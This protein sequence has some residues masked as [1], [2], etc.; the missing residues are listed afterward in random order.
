MIHVNKIQTDNSFTLFDSVPYDYFG[1]REGGS[2]HPKGVSDALGLK[3]EDVSKIT[4]V[5]L[6]SVRYDD[7]IPLQVRDRLEEIS[8]TI[9]MVAGFFDGDT[10]KTVLWFKTRNP[11]LGDIS[12]RDMIRLGR[13]ERLRKF[14]INAA[15]KKNRPQEHEI[16]N[17]V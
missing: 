4:S 9:N 8:N 16:S 11:L 3:R 2:F 14:I 6:S 12:P 5:S 10:E 13:F 1:F 15:I 17:M 7:A